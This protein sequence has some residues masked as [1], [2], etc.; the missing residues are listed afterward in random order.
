MSEDKRIVRIFTMPQEF[1]CGEGSTCCG[2]TGQTEEEIAA[3]KA[4]LEGLGVE[5]EVHNVKNV[6]VLN[7]HPNVFKLLRT[8]GMGAVPILAIGDEIVGMSV[9]SVEEAVKAVQEK[10]ISA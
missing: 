7:E 10:L 3:L 4:A 6:E 9:V 8:F 5:V 2:P 1:P